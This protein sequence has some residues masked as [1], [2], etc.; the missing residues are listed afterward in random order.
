MQ[1]QASQ[2][3]WEIVL[4]WFFTGSSL[5]GLP[6]G[7]R[8]VSLLR[9]VPPQT[10]A[11]FEWAARGPGQAGAA[12][13]DGF[14]ADQEIRQFFEFLDEALAKRSIANDDD[15]LHE[16]R[17]ELPQLAK[18]ITAHPGCLFV[19]FEPRPQN[20]AGIENWLNMLMGLHGG[21]ILSLGEDADATWKSLKITLS[22]VPEFVDSE[23]SPTQTIPLPIPGYQCVMHREGQ[24]ILMA[25]GDGTLTRTIEGLSG[26]QPG[27]DTNPRFREAI[28]RVAIPR[29]ATVGWLDVQGIV[30]S[31]SAALGPL[32]GLVKPVLAQVGA[33]ALDHVVQCSGVDNGTMMQR[34]FVA[35]SGRTDGIMTLVAGRPIQAQDFRHIPA[36]SDLVLAASINLTNIYREARQILSRV[37]P[38]SLRLFDESVKQL[39]AELEL[40]ILDDLLPA[41]GDLVTAFD[42]PASGGMIATSL[43]VGLEVRDQKKA[44]VVFDRLI[45][46]AEQS[47]SSD[48][49]ELHDE[50]GLI[51]SQPFLDNTIY[52]VGHSESGYGTGL[53]TRPCVCLTDR[54]L[55]LAVHPQAMKAQLRQMSSMTPGFD[56]EAKRKLALPDGEP[57]AYAFLNG[58]RFNGLVGAALPYLVPTFLIRLDLEGL[59]MDSFSFPSAAAIS[60]YFG[61]STATVVRKKDGLLFETKN[62]PPVIVSLALV[63]VYRAWHSTAFEFMEEAKRHNA[64]DA[65]QAQLGAVGDAVVPALAETKTPPEPAVKSN[66]PARSRWAPFLLKALAPNQ[67]QQLIPESTLNQLEEG[68][69]PSTIQRREAAQKRRED[70]RRR[71][72]ERRKGLPVVP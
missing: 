23:N 5:L 9:A 16:V 72:E 36:D 52:Y 66:P 45:K 65:E 15:P 61:D 35:T 71:R 42:S 54:H 64:L 18:R 17:R 11:Y 67:I 22:S 43:V 6:P 29:V 53:S 25:L 46:L 63:S 59:S 7:E 60:P 40:K 39:E 51:R 8:D 28:K 13:V 26:R 1:A 70:V 38:L 3:L 30:G 27:L 12:G 68:P 62:A 69:S 2:G 41:F 14:T 56:Q 50:L 48:H 20:K 31:A 44:A 37:Q 47:L 21:V 19:G 10:L 4:F 49:G 57:F 24:R 58:P 33:D 55:L 32:G 34:S